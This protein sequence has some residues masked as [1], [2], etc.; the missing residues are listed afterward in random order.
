MTNV[1]KHY[2]IAITPN[3]RNVITRTDKC[4][5]CG[6]DTYWSDDPDPVCKTCASDP[7]RIARMLAEARD[8]LELS[9]ASKTLAANEL[10]ELRAALAQ[11]RALLR[12]IEWQDA[13]TRP[14]FCDIVVCVACGRDHPNHKPDCELAALLA[15]DRKE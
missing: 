14:I 4:L 8:A 15:P 11:A 12:R 2:F 9:E 3:T 6:D 7:E 13:T 1:T 10:R 5:V